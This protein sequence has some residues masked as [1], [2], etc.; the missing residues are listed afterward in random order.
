MSG[1]RPRSETGRV[2]RMTNINKN[3]GEVPEL[4]SMKRGQGFRS[5]FSGKVATLFGVSGALG[6][7]VASRVGKTGTQVILP[8][9]GD[10]YDVLRLKLVG[11]LGQTLFTEWHLQDEASIMK[12]IKHSDVVI[13]MVGREWET[14]NFKFDD[15]HNEGARRLARCARQAGARTFIHVS[16]LLASENPERCWGKGSEYLKSKF[17][18]DMAVLEEFPDA[19][20]IRPSEMIGVNDWFSRYYHAWGR[21]GFGYQ[22]PL[23]RKGLY[24]VKAPITT[25]NVTDAIVAAIDDPNAKGKIYEATGPDRYTLHDLVEYMFTLL[26]VDWAANKYQI[27]DIRLMPLPLVKALVIQNMPFG[28]KMFTACTVEKL[29]RGSLSDMSQGYQ[30]V[31]DLGVKLDHIQDI[32][33]WH[34]EP[35]RKTRYLH[36]PIDPTQV[37]LKA[38][39]RLEEEQIHAEGQQTPLKILGL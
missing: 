13:N 3:A 9:R 22:I 16:H 23:W 15:V 17:R 27:M 1:D 12:A 10:H 35:W 26:D 4:T 6:R 14:K 5:S 33:F 30:S 28:Q 2:S 34:M 19:T 37:P 36:G 25:K 11:D 39:S 38:L 29:E 21:R 8:Y 7:H 24:T 31:V 32:L 20:I 18:G